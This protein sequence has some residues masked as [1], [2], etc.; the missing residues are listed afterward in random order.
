MKKSI[1]LG[2]LATAMAALAGV[3]SAQTKDVVL[4]D[5]K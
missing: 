3:A 2:L 4:V 5:P 1:K